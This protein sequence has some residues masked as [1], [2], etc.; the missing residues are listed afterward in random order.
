MTFVL[1]HKSCNEFV[2]LGL[3]IDQ[4]YT[5]HIVLL[6]SC[7]YRLR[8]ESKKWHVPS[9][10][11]RENSWYSLT[12]H[13][14]C[15]IGPLHILCILLT[16]FH[17]HTFQVRKGGKIVF[18][19]TFGTTQLDNQYKYR[20]RIGLDN[21]HLHMVNIWFRLRWYFSMFFFQQNIDRRTRSRQDCVYRESRTGNLRCHRGN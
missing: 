19:E 14:G 12:A 20:F 7:K 11:R 16:Q 8:T 15:C 5:W 2:H 13:L 10:F 3:N 6:H 4:G 21:V 9:K 18:V 1:V 17:F